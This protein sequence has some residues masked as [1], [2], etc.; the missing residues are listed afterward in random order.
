MVPQQQ[1]GAVPK[2]QC[3]ACTACCV[4]LPIPAGQI[5]PEE[6]PSGRRCPQLCQ[7]GC[8][9]YLLRPKMCVDFRC[10]WLSDP[11]W[12]EPLRP[13][14]SGLLCLRETLADGIPAALVYEMRTGV[15]QTP[16]A[17]EI[18]AELQRT[19]AVVVI[20]DAGQ[21][22]RQLTGTWQAE[23][24]QPIRQPRFIR[25]LRQPSAQPPALPGGK[26]LR[27]KASGRA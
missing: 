11:T 14:R 17:V 23:P 1:Q 21:H 9:I 26:P 5:G 16:E 20:I 27:R 25:T 22:R 6:K 12:P 15:L 8:G 19:T 24:Q 2:R 3:G 13:D 18:L 10:T 7:T 4:H